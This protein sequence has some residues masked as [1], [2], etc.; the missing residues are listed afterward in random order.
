MKLIRP[1]AE[2]L[3]ELKKGWLSEA[4]VLPV[5]E[6][7]DE[8]R[9]DSGFTVLRFDE[10]LQ[11]KESL[12]KFATSFKKAGV[13]LFDAHVD[14]LNHEDIVPFL[15]GLVGMENMI[16][17]GSR[18]WS[19]EEFYFIKDKNIRVFDMKEISLEGKEAVCDAVMSVAKDFG[20]LYVSVDADVLDSET[21]GMSTRELIYFL[22]RLKKLKNFKAADLCE[23]KN[24]VLAAKL[25]RELS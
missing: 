2:V 21:G 3:F 1:T 11:A 17:V 14:C 10:H 19:K 6:V 13:V 24:Q 23:F 25:V 4:G 9:F 12:R 16:I 15:T 5:F 22:Q 7:G 20:A 8:I 18:E